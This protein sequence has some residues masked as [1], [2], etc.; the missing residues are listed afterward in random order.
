MGHSDDLEDEIAG[1]L[2]AMTVIGAIVF[3]FLAVLAAMAAGAMIILLW[4]VYRRHGREGE[5]EAP[6]LNRIGS[7][8]VA[9]FLIAIVISPGLS[10]LGF[11]IGLLTF[12]AW[13]TKVYEVGLRRE[14]IATTW[15]EEEM[16]TLS[17]LSTYLVPF[18]PTRTAVLL[19]S[20]GNPVQIQK[21]EPLS[22]VVRIHAF[23]ERYKNLSTVIKTEK[24]D[25]FGEIVGYL[26][27]PAPAQSA[28]ETNVR[29]LLR[30]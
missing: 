7:Y 2:A 14:Q 6:Y 13:T 30:Q 18:D 16:A 25:N 11:V 29:L 21:P 15:S 19:E 17:S 8:A 23:N 12:L 1:K 27:T 28:T 24:L 3:A 20:E 4:Q 26:L 22:M 10:D 5:P 9:F